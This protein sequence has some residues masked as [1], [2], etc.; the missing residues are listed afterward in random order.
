MDIFVSALELLRFIPLCIV[1]GYAAFS[2]WKTGE[3]SNKVWWYALVGGLFTA[4]ETAVFFSVGLLIITVSYII[5]S[6]VVGFVSFG[7]GGGGA[8]SKALMTIGVSAP[9]FPLWSMFWP[10]PLP[11]MVLLFA[12]ALALPYMVLKK[13]KAPIWK[14]K[15]RFLPFMFIGLIVCVII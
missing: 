12:C 9:L 5:A 14:R 11:F 6:I 7:F 1:M 8:D 3:V 10:F 2:D 13:S 4:L 15:L